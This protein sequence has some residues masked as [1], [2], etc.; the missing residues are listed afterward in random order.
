[1]APVFLVIPKPPVIPKFPVIPKKFPVIPK[2][3]TFLRALEFLVA[4][5]TRAVPPPVPLQPS[6][7]RQ[8]PETRLLWARAARL[9]RWSRLARADVMDMDLLCFLPRRC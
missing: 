9:A 6:K 3:P 8:D 5:Q 4:A 7:A 2:F 1:V